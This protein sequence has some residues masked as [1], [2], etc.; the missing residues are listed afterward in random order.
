MIQKRLFSWILYI[1]VSSF[2]STADS[3]FQTIRKY[4]VKFRF[5]VDQT[6]CSVLTPLFPLRETHNHKYYYDS[7]NR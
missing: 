3:F 5:H 2:I 1:F 6:S 7:V 4:N